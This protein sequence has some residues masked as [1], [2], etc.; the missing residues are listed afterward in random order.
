MINQRKELTVLDGRTDPNYRKA[1][2]LKIN[3]YD[4]IHKKRKGAQK[5]NH[6][7]TNGQSQLRNN[8]YKTSNGC[9]YQK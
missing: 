3:K 9:L 6:G 4:N 7:R 8:C 1:T 2:F 5:K